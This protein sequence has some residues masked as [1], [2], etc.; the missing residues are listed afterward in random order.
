[1]KYNTGYVRATADDV[2]LHGLCPFTQQRIAACASLLEPI[3]VGASPVE[4]Q[5]NSQTRPYD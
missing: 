4:I 1:M 5:V 2:V 3:A